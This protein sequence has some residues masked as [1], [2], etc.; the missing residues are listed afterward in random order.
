MG[1]GFCGSSTQHCQ[2]DWC[3]ECGHIAKYCRCEPEGA[4][5]VEEFGDWDTPEQNSAERERAHKPLGE[6]EC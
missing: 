6:R 3:D 1:C 2:C 4:E 5:L